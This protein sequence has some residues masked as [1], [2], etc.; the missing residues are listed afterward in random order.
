MRRVSGRIQILLTVAIALASA[1]FVVVSVNMWT[2]ASASASTSWSLAPVAPPVGGWST[3][4]YLHGQ[5]LAFS[6]SG[7]VADSIDATTWTEQTVPVGSWRTVAYGAGH[8]VA[9]SSASVTPSELISTNAVQWS[10]LPGPPATPQRGQLGQWASITYGRGLFVAVSSVGTVA[11]SPDGVT[12]SLRFWRPQNI[13]TSVTYGD[14][15][16][17]A[18]DAAEGDALL[19]LNGL[20]WSLIRH[21]LTGLIQAPT[22]GLHL[23][24]VIYGNGNF[25]ALGASPSG[26]GY[27]ATSVYGYVWALH[28]YSPAQSIDTVAFGCGSFV[29]AGQSTSATN[30]I[31][32]SSTGAVWVATTPTTST[33]SNWTAVAYGAHHYVAVDVAG[34]IV[35]APS[36][37]NC[38]GAVPSPPQQVSGNVHAGQV[39]TYMHPPPGSGAAPVLGYRTTITN[40]VVTKSCRAPVYYEPNCIIKGLQD[41]Q[42]Y[43]V[44]AQ[45]YNRFGYSAP[46]D[47]EF[48]I[49]IAVWRLDTSTSPG[50]SASTLATVH[51]TGVI[52]DALGFYPT[53]AVTLHFGARL[54]TCVPN[55]FGE[56]MITIANPPAGTLRVFATYTGYGRSYRSPVHEVT[57]APTH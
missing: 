44:T 40:G 20:Q 14:G 6:P 41:H 1:V 22:A 49:P 31:I 24:A 36:A 30:P 17:I 43:W 56:C 8:Y 48:A 53:S 45:A 54:A 12:W 7:N 33:S 13:F 9:L 27:V 18:V 32:F 39:W 4:N 55:P 50:A 2:A 25:V 52:A 19:S 47:P 57:V 38:A 5:W 3:I 21:P 28:Q 35:S 26:A 34:D 42:V 29:A 37:P 10:T 11:T 46:S 51:V 23:G 16:F 15:R